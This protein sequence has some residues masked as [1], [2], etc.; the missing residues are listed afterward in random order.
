MPRVLYVAHGHP[1]F[2]KGGGELAAWRLFQ[3]C[4]Q[5]YGD[6]SCAFLAAAS[7]PQQLPPGCGVLGLGPREWLI[8]PSSNALIHD[9]VINLSVGGPL[10]QAMESYQPDLIHMHHYLHVGIDLVLTLK[11]WFPQALLV[12]TLHEYWAMCA[13]EGRLL[14]ASGELCLGPDPSAC[15]A[16]LDQPEAR[17]YLEIRSRRVKRLFAAIDHFIAP[18]YFLKKTYLH[19]GGVPLHRISVVENLPP[20]SSPSCCSPVLAEPGSSGVRLGYFGQ[21]NPWKG[22]NLILRALS[23]LHQ[24]QLPMTLQ[25]HGLDSALLH[26]PSGQGL[27]PFLIECRTLI[28]ALGPDR[29]MIAGTYEEDDLPARMAQVDCVLMAS[30]WYENSPMIIQESF[31]HGRPVIAPYLGG[32]AEKVRPEF[33]GLLY[34]A[35]QSSAL[36]ASLKRLADSPELLRSLSHGARLSAQ[37]LDRVAIQHERIYRNLLLA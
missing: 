20:S 5:V 11:C 10:H 27:G 6:G 4:S 15:A 18:S 17:V 3:H 13:Y 32:M 14:R 1:R 23:S 24:L 33:N 19:W 8:R 12:L 9:S 35:G 36:A 31:I 25:I 30:T 29:V 7:S 2:A 37:R 16:C 22:L 34:H 28:E 26:N 21:V